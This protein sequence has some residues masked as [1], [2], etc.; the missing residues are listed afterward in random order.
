MSSPPPLPSGAKS[1]ITLTGSPKTLLITLYCRYNDCQ[2]PRPILNDKWAGH[3]LDQLD[4][5]FEEMQPSSFFCA[6][7]SLRTRFLDQWTTEFLNKHRDE[8]VTVLH[9]ACGLDAR[10]H[11]VTWGRNVRWIDVDLPEVVELRR[12]LLP[13]PAGDYTLLAGSVLDDSI[14]ASIPNDRLTVVVFEGLL[15]YLQPSDAEGLITRLCTR[16]ESNG[17]ELLLDGLG[18][19]NLALQRWVGMMFNLAWLKKAKATWSYAVDDP[20]SL[21]RLHP[22]LKL[23]TALPVSDNDGI[24]D[25]SYGHQWVAWLL[26][27]LPGFRDAMLFLRFSFG[28]SSGV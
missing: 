2:T 11:R 16:F 28:A 22:G 17:G 14:L 20:R 15:M 12:K 8:P 1:T 23:V 18:W 13:E 7:M 6:I 19:V 5:N 27:L 24:Q 9:L 25:M 21:E 10:A 26:A 3:V 4:F